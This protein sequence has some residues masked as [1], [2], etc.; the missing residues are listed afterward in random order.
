MSH[1]PTDYLTRLCGIKPYFDVRGYGCEIHEMSEMANAHFGQLMFP[2]SLVFISL[3]FS[4]IVPSRVYQSPNQKLEKR[5]RLVGRLS[6]VTK[7]MAA[8]LL[9]IPGHLGAVSQPVLA[10][11]TMT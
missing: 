2:I 8:S 7:V 9:N 6:L 10:S 4:F 1:S 3:I 11:L 5:L